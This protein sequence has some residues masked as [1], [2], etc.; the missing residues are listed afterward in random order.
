MATDAPESQLLDAAPGASLALTSVEVHRL[1]G[2]F[3]YRIDLA[4]SDHVP[5]AVDTADGLFAANEERL[6]LLYG[7]NGTGKTSLLRLLFHALSSAGNKG[8]RTTV[9]N[10]RFARL[11]VRFTDGTLIAY[12]RSED[13]LSGPF[14]AEIHLAGDG[15]DP[16]TWNYSADDQRT[17]VYLEDDLARWPTEATLRSA[18]SIT[19][20]REDDE[21]RFLRTLDELALNPVLLS[22]SRAITADVLPDNGAITRRARDRARRGLDPDDE[23]LRE[24]RDIDVVSAL[25]RVRTYL[26]Q[27]AFAGT[28]AGS[29]RVDTVYLNVAAAIVQHASKVGR[30]N[31]T[32]LPSLRE[33]V[34]HLGERSQRF[35]SYGLLPEFPASTLNAR[36]ADAPSRNGPLLEHVLNPYL[37]GL[38]ERM[39]ALE[40]GLHAVASFIDA[41]NS[42]LESKRAEFRPGPFGIR[43][44]DEDTGEPLEPSELSSGEK[45]VVLLFSDI[46]ALQDHTRL[47][48]IDEPE[49]SLNPQWQRKLMPRL[50]EVTEQSGMQLL[51][52]THSIEI[53]AQYRDRI[54]RLDGRSA[55]A[56]D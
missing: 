1:H 22:D 21:T 42:F 47:F 41:L 23:A 40:P 45:Q 12:S 44:F 14:R 48:I 11:A 34:S 4:A 5:H 26:S 49:L 46:V 16:I 2:K 24:R 38:A 9:L 10:T 15:T 27:L 50:L 54:H 53:M 13:Q 32:L 28:Q 31:Q 25:E 7:N 6:T 52:A 37:D 55:K 3:S 20:F 39:D 17:S 19:L 56:T 36:L 18:G 8:H 33:K 30:P 29:Q 35:H 43:I 51:A